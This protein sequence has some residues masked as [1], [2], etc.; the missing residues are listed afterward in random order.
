MQED[1]RNT[2]L[3]QNCYFFFACP[4]YIY[5]RLF[6]VKT[7]GQSYVCVPVRVVAV[8]WRVEEGVEEPLTSNCG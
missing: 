3:Q 5:V 4:A 8:L 6:D 7:T 1:Y 2:G